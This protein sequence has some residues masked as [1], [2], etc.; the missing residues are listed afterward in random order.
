MQ[1]FSDPAMGLRGVIRVPGD[2]S[3]SHRALMLAAVA[4]GTTL[5]D[6]LLEGEDCLAT[7]QILRELGVDIRK[8][9]PGIWMV[10]GQGWDALVP[11]SGRRL[12]VG[13]SGTS[14]RLL[15]GLLGSGRIPLCLDGD[16]SI[17]RR[18][19]ARIL[20]PLQKMGVNILGSAGAKAPLIISPAEHV[21]GIDYRMPVASAQVK[22]SILFAGLRAWGITRVYESAP[23]RD[24]T[25]RMLRAF[26]Q[27]LRQMG[28]Y[29][30]LEGGHP[31]QTPGEIRI[32][33]DFSSAMFFIVAATIIP[34]SEILLT[35]VGI[36]PTRT[37]ALTLLRQMGADITL[38]H[39]R[40]WSGE[41]VADLIVRHH[42]L[43]GIRVSPDLVS[44]AIDE[45]PALAVA[46]ACAHG[47]TLITAAGELRVKES[48]RILAIVEGLRAVG[49]RAVAYPDGMLIHG[50]T[51]HGGSV[52]SFGDHRIA[53]AFAIAGAASEKGVRVRNCASVTTSFPDFLAC[54]QGLNMPVRET[55]SH[56][57]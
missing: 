44:G 26:D 2:K 25:E 22:S 47:P 17:R 14:M 8:L 18:P 53:M 43:E 3:I 29:V 37:A 12:D 45:F 41:P 31:L 13:N 55:A 51:I 42:S 21:T 50:A 19:M 46:A 56:D 10:P 5:I 24:H 32:P 11:P 23:T 52:N 4:H 38:S 7:A 34:G 39:A 49:I 27:P 57:S 33:A 9:R 35:D 1:Y 40:F 30:E 6:G 28:H 36:N 48:D 54:A 15:A 16:A 20:S